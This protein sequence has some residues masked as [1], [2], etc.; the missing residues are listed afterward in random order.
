MNAIWV[1]GGLIVVLLAL[2]L[3]Y[4]KLVKEQNRISPK[5]KTLQRHLFK[6]RIDPHFLFNALSSI[7]S[8]VN[9]NDR[10]STLKYLSRFAAL[11][12]KIMLE[13][14][15]RLIT[16]EEEMKLLNHYR[17]LA[18]LRFDQPFTWR[19]SALDGIDV[20]GT[21]QRDELTFS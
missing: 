10:E 20:H 13:P 11:L 17:A 14:G 1:I 19:V 6:A 15:D 3:Q 21:E 5:N 4:W 16:L 2:L 8:L 18:S 7:Q 9:K 12:R